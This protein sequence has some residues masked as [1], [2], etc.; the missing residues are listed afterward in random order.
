MLLLW[1]PLAVIMIISLSTR[2]VQSIG[3]TLHITVEMGQPYI[4]ILYYRGKNG[5]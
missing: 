2:I 5:A 1:Y 4:G 3:E